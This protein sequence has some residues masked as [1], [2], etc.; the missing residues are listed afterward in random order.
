M[1]HIFPSYVCRR[2]CHAMNA[3]M[4]NSVTL[5]LQV[6]AYTFCLKHRRG[7]LVCCFNVFLL[8]CA[9]IEVTASRFGCP[10]MN[11]FRKSTSSAT[12]GLRRVNHGTS[13]IDVAPRSTVFQL[14]KRCRQ[15]SCTMIDERKRHPCHRRCRHHRPMT[16]GIPSASFSQETCFLRRPC[17]SRVSL[18]LCCSDAFFVRVESMSNYIRIF[19]VH[20]C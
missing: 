14:R 6:C 3:L 15:I 5:Y 18:L 7:G 13:G 19:M 4:L 16:V 11:T 2:A 12:R 1:I 8:H 20:V 9:W 17:S 10:K